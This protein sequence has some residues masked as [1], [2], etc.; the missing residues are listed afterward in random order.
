MEFLLW[1]LVAAANFGGTYFSKLTSRELGVQKVDNS[2][3]LLINGVSACLFF[4]FSSGFRIGIN[5][6]TLIYAIIFALVVLGS[7][8]FNI[9]AYRYI[10]VSNLNII[11]NSGSLI[12]STLL[13]ILLFNEQLQ[14]KD[15]FRTGLMLIAV[16]LILLSG[17]SSD[18]PAKKKNFFALIVI[19]PIS[20]LLTVA[21][22]VLLKFYGSA[23]G[24]LN[25]DSLFFFTNVV[26][27]L[28]TVLRLIFGGKKVLASSKLTLPLLAIFLGNT[29][30]SN[31]GS[32]L[33][34]QLLKFVD[35]STY[36]PLITAIN[37]IG[38]AVGSLV[39]K[40][41]LKLCD[42]LAVLVAVV[43]IMIP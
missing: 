39:F 33:S 7:L 17:K 21:S 6:P 1:P 40:E 3:F 19:I 9:Y 37:I 34:A 11:K 30:S 8:L 29:V 38:G 36:T 26:L 35:I 25:A 16:F 5:T 20:I 18:N 27:I 12:V 22:S 13:G 42:I 41:K 23:K 43:A 24:V 28:F 10:S 31:V 32:L 15:Y 4:A 14:L 2:L